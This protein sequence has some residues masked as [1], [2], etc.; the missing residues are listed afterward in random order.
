MIRNPIVAGA[1]YPEEKNELS[2]MIKSFL[3]DAKSRKN[4]KLK[5]LIVPHAGYI[6]SGPIAAEGYNTIEK[7]F[8]KVIL[9]GPSH[10]VRFFGGAF[11]SNDEWETPLGKV[12]IFRIKSKLVKN[13]ELAHAHEHSLE[14]QVPFLQKI[15]GDFYLC[16]ISLG[17]YTEELINDIVDELDGDTLL[18]ISSDLSHYNPYEMAN[19][20]DKKTIQKILELKPEVE[21]DEACGA[22]G[23][24][25]LINIAKKLGWKPALLDY[26]NSG[27][28]AGDKEGVVGYASIAFE[29]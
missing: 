21:H 20:I 10:Q 16:S 25:I 26:R 5:A 11:D 18:V 22:D 6:Y 29:E 4:K 13:N 28:T 2:G 27:D 14:V 3:K 24:N 7:K 15:L 12:K 17:S 23:I 8:Q 9:L 19:N 1:F